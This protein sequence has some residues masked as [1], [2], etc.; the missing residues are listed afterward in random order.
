MLLSR[1]AE[2]LGIAFQGEDR[3]ISGLNTLEAAGPDE[4]SFLA[5]PKYAQYLGQTRAGAVIVRPEYASSVTAAL[6]S[7]EPYVDFGRTLALFAPPVPAFEGVSDRA[8]VHPEAELGEGVSVFPFAYIGKGAKIG[9]GCRIFPGCYVGEGCRVGKKTIL[10]PNVVLME[11]TEVGDHCILH[12][13]A[14]VGADGFGFSRI[15]GG[16]VKIPQIGRAVIEDDVEI[17]ANTTVDRAVLNVT[18]VGR[19]TKIDNLVQLGHNV[20]VGE[21]C[22]IVALS[23]IAGSTRL[24]NEVTLAAHSGV[25]GH[26]KIGNNVTI[27]PFS[28]LPKDVPDNASVGGIPAMEG[29]T[30]MRWVATMPKLPDM[31][32]RLGALEKELAQLKAALAAGGVAD[33]D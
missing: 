15:P 24:G 1:I 22:F 9:P 23:G 32:K 4:L 17:G 7:E 21:R 29:P 8:Y 18:R 25:S 27:G 3:E 5:N 33:K 28:A 13:G 16:I 20:E 30:F 2:A 31:H 14:V 10:Y 19:E 26:L 11:R 6:I 12:A